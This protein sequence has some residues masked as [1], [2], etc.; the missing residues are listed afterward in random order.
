MKKAI[1]TA[2]A[3]VAIALSEPDWAGAN[4]GSAD[5][6]NN[7]LIACTAAPGVQQGY[8]YGYINAIADATSNNTI[9]GFKACIP[10]QVQVEQLRD[11]VIQYL[12]NHP[13][14]RHYSVLG[15]VAKALAGAFPCR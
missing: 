12:R 13:A 7:L 10:Q 1:S 14:E 4:V 11:V 15:L 2:A 5:D 8:C 9:D 3:I 6:G